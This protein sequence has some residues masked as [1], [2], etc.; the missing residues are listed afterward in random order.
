ME[1][2]VGTFFQL[3][4]MHATWL[5]NAQSRKINIIMRHMNKPRV[6]Q[7]NQYNYMDLKKIYISHCDK[8]RVQNHTT[9]LKNA[10]YNW[11]SSN[12]E[13]TLNLTVLVIQTQCRF[14]NDNADLLPKTLT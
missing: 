10:C 1:N 12:N 4:E 2:Q 13:L 11:I 3:S 14:I 7:E 5:I 8:R 6:T 9:S